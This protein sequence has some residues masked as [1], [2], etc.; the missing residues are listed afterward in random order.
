MSHMDGVPFYIF[1]RF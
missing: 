1:L